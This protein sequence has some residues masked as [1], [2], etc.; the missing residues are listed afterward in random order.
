MAEPEGSSGPDGSDEP[1]DDSSDPKQLELLEA[2]SPRR[3][4]RWVLRKNRETSPWQVRFMHKV[5][6]STGTIVL[7]GVCGW[8][9]DFLA[10]LIG[11]T[12]VTKT[13]GVVFAFAVVLTC[14]VAVL[15]DMIE[16][17]LRSWPWERVDEDGDE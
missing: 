4:R 16:F 10:G 3:R 11:Q 13:M 7:V 9:V 14:S 5:L 1:T 8:I 17:V 6:L 12:V 15:V 2:P